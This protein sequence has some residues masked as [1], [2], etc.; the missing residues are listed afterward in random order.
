MKS[1]VNW[2]GKLGS[3]TSDVAMGVAELVSAT[4]DRARRHDESE[5]LDNIFDIGSVRIEAV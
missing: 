3:S 1:S 4:V 5:G 2:K